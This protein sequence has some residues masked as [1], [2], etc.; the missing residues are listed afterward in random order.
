MKRQVHL[1]IGIGLFL[2]Y[3]YM[4]GLF[5]NPAGELFVFGIIAVAAG[6]LF[7]DILEPA[8][9]PR[10]RGIFHSRRVLKGSALLF[11]FTAAPVM[12]IPVIP[13]LAGVFACSC[14][15]LG[16]AGHL[17]ADSVTRAGLPG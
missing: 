4:T 17:L 15:F 16:Y 10:H 8:T 5:H 14:F 12:L 9:S 2:A 3:G 6:S 13:H 11:L 7:P 1:I